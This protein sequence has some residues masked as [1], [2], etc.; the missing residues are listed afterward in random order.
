MI[1][2]AESGRDAMISEVR[3]M[4]HI[5]SIL[6]DAQGIASV[7]GWPVA[8][9]W[10]ISIAITLPACVRARNLQ[11]AD[12]RMGNGPF[13]VARGTARAELRGPQVFSGLREIWVR[14]VYL[15]DDFLTI[16]EDALV[17]DLGA[18]LGNFTNLALAQHRDVRVVAVEPSLTLSQSLRASVNGNRWL[19]RVAIKRAFVGT[20]TTVQATVA[21]DPDHSG[22]PFLAEEDFLDEFKI[23]H[24]DFLKCDIEGSEFFLLEPKS[25]L[26][27]ITQNLAIEIHAWGGSVA[28]FLE[29]LRSIGFEVG[30][31]TYEANGTCIALCRRSAQ[32]DHAARSVKKHGAPIGVPAESLIG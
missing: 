17:V 14:D 22:A 29:H 9:R 15:K 21:T 30:P 28:H 1:E 8:L 23:D 7:C 27:S 12:R 3:T 4:V 24:V 16:L 18:N 6:R 20:S 31:V 11:P 10:L 32:S 13:P 26:L 19:E 5:R 25:K 2:G